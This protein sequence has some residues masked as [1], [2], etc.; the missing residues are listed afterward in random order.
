MAITSAQVQQL[1]VAYLGR[2]ADKGGLDYWLGELNAEP[3]KITLDQ[4]RANFVNEQAEYKEV[5][6]G[7]SRVDTV[8]KIYN[9]LFGRAPDAGGLTYWTTGGGA[10]VSIDQLL[11]A[12]INGASAADAKVVANKVLVSEVYTETAGANYA[13]E[14]ATSILSGVDG[15]ATSVAEA[16]A[17][18]E[19][20][21]LSGIAIPAGVAALKAQ[22]LA[23]K[24]VDDFEAS[25]VNE[26]VELNKAVVDL[27]ASSGNAVVLD[28]LDPVAPGE[29]QTYAGADQAIQN[30]LDLREAIGGAT[31]VLQ[32]AAT[33]AA[34][35]LQ[36]TRL[37]YTQKDTG[38]VDKAVAYEKA[39]ATDASLKAA[40]DAAVVTA[41][42]KA[43]VDFAAATTDAAVL[44]KANADAG[45][46]PGTVTDT[47][48]LYTELTNKDAT[49]AQI[50]A[51]TDAF[52]V[53][54]KDST[55]YKTLKSL[56]ATDYAKNVAKQAVTDTA[57]EITG[58]EGN[59]Y[60]KDVA[61][62][63]TADKTLADAKAADAL[64]A[65][66]QA[67]ADAHKALE[68]A[69]AAVEVPGNAKELVDTVAPAA[70]DGTDK[71]DLFHFADKATSDDFTIGSGGVTNFAKGDAIY[72]GEGYT[73]NST[74][75]FDSTTNQYTGSNTGA[76]EV[77]FGKNA[78]GDVTV[79]VEANAVG[80]VAAAGTTDNVSVITL[81]GVTD[82]SQVT[83]ANGVVSHV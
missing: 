17:K 39:L 49:P 45:L 34:T 30:A 14:D 54:L 83:F 57:S 26:L 8:T 22:A 2:A 77:F 10:S 6:G 43:Q 50:K 73:L 33:Q 81:T 80:N 12:F 51:I 7:L 20:G 24:A 27:K 38:N 74:A 59:A 36:A 55:D 16:V 19:D 63:A 79:T 70:N 41:K 64:V 62:K 46:A 9:N 28:P 72:V 61:D 31:S 1:Y 75:T 32:A 48:T 37:A 69:A 11:V 56:A 67:I 13:K 4:I 23:E 3:A 42:A 71:A 76:L 53:L 65:K 35:D 52:D 29:K 25:K 47:V 21:S 40:D 66:A 78:A 18:L 60:K 15:T 68:D 5:Y 82:V 58:T 44:V